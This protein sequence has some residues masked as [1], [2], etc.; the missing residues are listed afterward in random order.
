MKKLFVLLL[1]IFCST[2]AYSFPWSRDELPTSI[3]DDGEIVVINK[4]DNVEDKLRIGNETNFPLDV[5][6]KG[7]HN[8]QGLI[9]IASG[10]IAAHDTRYL[11]SEW[12]DNL[13]DFKQ[14]Y[15]SIEGGKITKYFAQVGSSDL[16]FNIY[17]TDIKQSDNN[18]YYSPADELIKWKQL[19]DM[20]GITQE[21]YGAKKKQL[22]G[23]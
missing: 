22:L 17:E 2:M 5:I 15:I 7:D 18:G 21:E 4:D 16:L 9:V 13:E 8:K 20:G 10:N 3:N 14:F 23:L 19:F 11:H 6:I 12:E 1:I